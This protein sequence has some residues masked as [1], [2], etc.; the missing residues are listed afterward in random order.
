MKVYHPVQGRSLQH[1]AVAPKAED[2]SVGVKEWEDK[3]GEPVTLRVTFVHGV[4]EV[5][6]SLGRFLIAR[7]HA[8]KSRPLISAA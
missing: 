2:P 7:K 6:D 4:A 3:D 8:F 5:D 1:L